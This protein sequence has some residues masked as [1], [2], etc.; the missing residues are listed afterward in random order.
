M[1]NQYV[2]ARIVKSVIPFFCQI[3][4][5]LVPKIPFKYTFNN[6]YKGFN[7]SFRNLKGFLQLRTDGFLQL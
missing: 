5:K 6:N 3:L 1:N 4:T 7:K 2:S